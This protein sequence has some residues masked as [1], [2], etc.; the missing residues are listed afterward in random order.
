M[1]A[2]IVSNLATKVLSLFVVIAVTGPRA[3]ASETCLSPAEQA[4][5]LALSKGKNDATSKRPGCEKA[6]G[7]AGCLSPIDQARLRWYRDR[8]TECF[9]GRDSELI[10]V[11]SIVA[12]VCEGSGLA[13]KD[14]FVLGRDEMKLAFT[15]ISEAD[16]FL[17]IDV[18]TQI[19]NSRTYFRTGHAAPSVLEAN[20][21]SMYVIDPDTGRSTHSTAEFEITPHPT[22]I[23]STDGFGIGGS[24]AVGETLK[25]YL[26]K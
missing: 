10:G 7:A 5:Y 23:L 3:E 2:N 8:S 15:K 6:Y 17:R 4:E 1:K 25:T 19:Q 14:A 12:R 26:R 16:S 18:K 21:L 20:K 24:C 22:L 13:A 9:M 11:W